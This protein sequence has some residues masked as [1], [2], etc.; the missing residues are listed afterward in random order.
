MPGDRA[1]C[2]APAELVVFR[3]RRKR[4]WLCKAHRSRYTGSGAVH[5][6]C[7]ADELEYVEG[8]PRVYTGP[9]RACGEAEG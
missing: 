2:P 5:P 4:L 6:Y 9:P 1:P 3:G 7:D 8:A